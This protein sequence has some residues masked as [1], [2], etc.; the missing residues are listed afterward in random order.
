M[1]LN[2]LSFLLWESGKIQ[3]VS[4][5]ERIKK[6]HQSFNPTMILKVRKK[7]KKITAKAKCIYKLKT[8]WWDFAP[9]IK[10]N[11]QEIKILT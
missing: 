6:C 10:T 1:T 3:D 7:V 9:D 2:S 4:Q 5:P 11:S 8:N